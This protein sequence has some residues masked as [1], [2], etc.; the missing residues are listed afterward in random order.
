MPL[1]FSG[2]PSKT[3]YSSSKAALLGF[4]NALSAELYDTGVSVSVVI[5]PAVNTNLI[6]SGMA[7]DEIKKQQSKIVL[8]GAACVQI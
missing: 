8:R 5:P 4:A 6:K 3:A 7:Y 2:F 1:H